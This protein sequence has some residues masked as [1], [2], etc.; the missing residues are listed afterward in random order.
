VAIQWITVPS[1]EQTKCIAVAAQDTL[2]DQLIS[3]FTL[4]GYARL[5]FR[6]F[7]DGTIRPNPSVRQGGRTRLRS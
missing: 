7:H 1:D 3:V 2:N 4:I 6:H 5:G